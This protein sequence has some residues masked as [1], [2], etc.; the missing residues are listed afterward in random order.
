MENGK[1]PLQIKKNFMALAVFILIVLA[2]VDIVLRVYPPLLEPGTPGGQIS[3]VG[4]HHQFKDGSSYYIYTVFES[5]GDV[6]QA[7]WDEKEW[8]Q[9][10]VANYKAPTRPAGDEE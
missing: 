2:L 6:Y 5:N 8:N 10:K 9:K 3:A 7:W 1:D 4:H